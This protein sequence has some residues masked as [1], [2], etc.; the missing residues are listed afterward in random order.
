MARA[1]TSG[2]APTLDSVS[3]DGMNELWK[4]GDVL[5]LLPVIPPDAPPEVEYALRLRRD[6]S[7]SG[8]CEM[9][10]AAF[11]VQLVE[12]FGS[13]SI[14]AGL[15]PHRGNCLAADENIFPLVASFYE[16]R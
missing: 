1:Y 10:G 11:G 14:S 13:G 7:L 6:A 3:P 12:D 16:T 8:Q 5:F 2:E 4:L 9:C 15:F